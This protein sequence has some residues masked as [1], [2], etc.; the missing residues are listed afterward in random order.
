MTFVLA[1]MAT[2]GLTSLASDKIRPLASQKFR[3]W[4][5]SAFGVASLMGDYTRVDIK[6]K[7]SWIPP[8]PP[9][10][11]LDLVLLLHNLWQ[12]YA[13]MNLPNA[14][15]QDLNVVFYKNTWGWTPCFAGGASPQTSPPQPFLC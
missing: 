9:P 11:T 10:T 12:F 1:T 13:I 14:L 6:L 15:K 4:V 8:P 7:R 5:S 3:G 2:F